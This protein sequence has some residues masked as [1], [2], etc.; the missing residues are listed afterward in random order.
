M[1][2]YLGEGR[3]SG[4]VCLLG[5][6]TPWRPGWPR[7]H[8]R[9]ESRKRRRQLR[10][11]NSK[12]EVQGTPSRGK[13]DGGRKV[14]AKIRWQALR[15]P[16]QETQQTWVWSLGQEDPLEEEMEMH[17]RIL[18]WKVPWTEKPT[19]HD[20]TKSQTGLSNSMYPLHILHSLHSQA[21]ARCKRWM[22]SLDV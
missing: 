16:K 4:R 22:N 5:L 15:L 1:H 19:N 7:W 11:R 9:G 13:G 17:T 21:G 3:S 18:A 14:N 12:I 10:S 2:P 20:V 8:E 6:W